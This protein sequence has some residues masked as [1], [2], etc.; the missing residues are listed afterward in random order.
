MVLLAPSEPTGA[1]NVNSGTLSRQMSALRVRLNSGTTL[2]ARSASRQDS[3]SQRV[4]VWARS[5][6]AMDPRNRVALFFTSGAI[7]HDHFALTKAASFK[8]ASS[9]GDPGAED[10]SLRSESSS[11]SVE[12]SMSIRTRR[13][14]AALKDRTFCVFR[15]TSLHALK[16]MIAG[17][18][19]GKGLNIKG[20]SAKKGRLV[21]FVP[22]L[23][24][25]SEEQ[26]GTQTSRRSSSGGT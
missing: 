16:H 14:V 4:R 9:S 1:Y 17:T 21:G 10:E 8:E 20:K 15:P 7:M 12:P 25:H 26:T 18:G 22:F 13:R 24:I 5:M 23:Q 2:R 11:L 19:V 3:T 6:K